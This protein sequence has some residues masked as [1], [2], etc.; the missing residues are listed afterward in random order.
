MNIG[1][2]AVICSVL[3]IY[4]GTTTY[5]QIMGLSFFGGPAGIATMMAIPMALLF[6]L[7]NTTSVLSKYKVWNNGNNKR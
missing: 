5:E 1:I 3:A 6:D 2:S 4:F 7:N